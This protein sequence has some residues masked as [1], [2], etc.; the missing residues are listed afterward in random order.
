M[1]DDDAPPG[2][3]EW[4]VTYGDMMSLL[5]TF[6]I[7]LVSMSTVKQEGRLRAMMNSLQ[8]R[9]GPLE[10]PFGAP[11]TSTQENS[12]LDQPAS[13]SQSQTGGTETGGRVSRGLSGPSSS[14]KRLSHG[15]HVSLGG[16]ALFDF[17][18]AKLN[19]AAQENLDSIK[20]V[21]E[22][23]ANCILVRGHATRDELSPAPYGDNLFSLSYQRSLAAANYLVKLGIPRSRLFVAAAGDAEPIVVSRDRAQQSRNRRVDVMI[24]DT[25]T[26]KIDD[27]QSVI[28]PVRVAEEIEGDS[29]R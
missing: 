10:G 6:F 18:S 16:P 21:L 27:G 14:V 25:Y 1:A 23:R 13:R 19:T 7:M 28:R 3:P 15:T 2:V 29:L 17:R 26:S 12:L 22:N 9:F 20:R 4:V 5:L 8:E 24:L 11:G